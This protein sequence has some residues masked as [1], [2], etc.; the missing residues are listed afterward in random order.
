LRG[1]IQLGIDHGVDHLAVVGALRR[2][3]GRRLAHIRDFDVGSPALLL[4][5]IG[6]VDE[7][8]VADE[9]VAEF[10]WSVH[11]SIAVGK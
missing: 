5:A 1:S 9:E 4:A 3:E 10:G 8:L 11:G 7:P 6:R 2:D